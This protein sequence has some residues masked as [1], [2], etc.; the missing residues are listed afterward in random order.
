MQIDNNTVSDIV[1]ETFNQAKSKATDMIY[2]WLMDRAA[3]QQFNIYWD[4]GVKNLAEYF[5]KYHSGVHQKQVR[6]TFL[7][8]KGSPN[9]LQGCIKLLGVRVPKLNALIRLTGINKQAI[10]A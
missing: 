6:S 1:S 5:S 4:R 7:L 2:Y 3:Q 10:A 8:T 9:S